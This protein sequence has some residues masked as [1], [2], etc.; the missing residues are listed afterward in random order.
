ME[1]QHASKNV[2]LLRQKFLIICIVF[3]IAILTMYAFSVYYHGFTSYEAVIVAFAVMFA[4]YA[5]V[6]YTR[7]LATLDRIH[8]ALVLAK[9]GKTH[10]RITETKGLGEIG[11]VAWALND[12]LDIIET[13][14][15][16]LAN[17]FEATGKGK[18][19]RKLMPDGMPQ[20]FA[21]TMKEV[22][23]AIES[24]HQVNIFGRQNR[25]KSEL[26]RIN[27]SNL[28]GNLKNNQAEL[29]NLSSKMD[30]VLNIAT[31]SRD[32]AEESRELAE[33]I[34]VAL[35]SMTSCMQS[36]ESTAQALGEE[37]GR[38]SET[39]D[40]ITNIAEQ[41]NLLALNAA[42]EA[43]R[44]GEV[45]RGFAV[46][47]DEVRLLADRTRQSTQ[48]ISQTIHSLT[49]RIDEVVSQTSEVAEQTSIVTT[50]VE[51]FHDSFD[52]V[53]IASEETIQLANATKDMSF[54]SLVKLD[55]IVYMQ[56]G[57]IALEKNGQGA[58]A[59]AVKV[60]HFNCR[61]GQWYYNGQG[62]DSF[63]HLSSYKRMESSHAAVH[64]NVHAAMDLVKQDWLND[65]EVLSE[66][67]ASVEK[68]E[69]ASLGVVNAITDVVAEKHAR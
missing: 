29:V 46:V 69:D 18:Y 9:S 8:Q 68:A 37:S 58:E 65:D 27:T 32:G 36:M 56:N 34:R 53:A 30:D 1:K 40:V 3:V 66:L 42:I 31:Q 49:G 52:K 43:A 26:H 48:D 4:V 50:E 39:I 20:D 21:N 28:L 25:L 64:A 33:K 60:D 51:H 23:E 62:Y 16:E 11:F 13:N 59:D 61:L 15:R 38:I 22:N 63:R 10:V 55:H 5:Y 47:A 35:A 14:S 17:S 44:A 41:T 54:A 6:D 24:M 57:Y 67:L 12:F 19:Y 2:P 7:P 45:G